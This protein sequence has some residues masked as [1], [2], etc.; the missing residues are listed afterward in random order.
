[1]QNIKLTIT[2]MQIENGEENKVELITDG[3]LTDIG[4]STILEFDE[5][6]LYDLHDVRTSVK[7]DSDYVQM[8]RTGD[9]STNMVFAEE[10]TYE[11][12]Y[13][14]P[15]GAIQLDIFPIKV[16]SSRNENGGAVDLEY[17]VKIGDLRAHNK[18]NIVYQKKN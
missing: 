4:D 8:S 10:K 5:S 7:I 6:S 18:F 14:T 2:G 17:E 3:V 12:I 16:K 1:M 9:I 15:F 11:A 13:T